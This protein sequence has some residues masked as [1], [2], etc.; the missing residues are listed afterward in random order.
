[1][2]GKSILVR[3]P[4]L[5]L[6]LSLGS[7]QLDSQQ[8]GELPSYKPTQQY[9]GTIHSWGHGFLKVAMKN[10]E[11]GFHKFQPDVKFDDSLVSSAAAMA[12]LYTGRADIG[13][14]AREITPPEIAAYE[15]MTQQKLFPI[16]VLTGS[17]GNPDKIMA[18]GIFVNK[19]NP[20]AQLTFDQL[21]AIFSAERRR[22][23]KDLIRTWG[24]LGLTGEWAHHA[25][26]PYSGPAFEAPGY[27]F[28]QTV[29]NGSV[30]WN[31]DLKQLED[32]PVPNAHDVDG[33]QRIVDAVGA[34]RYAI[35]ISGAG[36][37]NPNAKLIAIAR[38]GGAF[39]L[40]TPQNVANRSYPL[41]RPVRF[42][43][44]NGPRVP[45]NPVVLEFFRYILS[46]EGQQDALREG[47]FFAIPDEVALRERTHL[48]ATPVQGPL[49]H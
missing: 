48:E 11:A 28:S 21:D 8:S 17:L 38:P 16:D 13:V 24:Q 33:Y 30:L 25:I 22:G 3:L 19:D 20:L 36:Y 31:C 41:S 26:Q 1:M 27:F 5:F 6:G 44:N 43:I 45:P 42:Y 47:D 46:R 18:L 40:P 34:D 32:L 14:L 49:A 10:W 37:K 12:G 39:V 7:S 2:N 4:L 23:E 15:K 29:L 35:A 9:S